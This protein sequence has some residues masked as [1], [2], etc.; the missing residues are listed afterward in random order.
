VSIQTLYSFLYPHSLE[1]NIYT[2]AL[3]LV[4]VW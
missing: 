1:L 3:L 4:K 2:S